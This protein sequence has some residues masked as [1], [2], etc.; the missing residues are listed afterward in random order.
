MAISLVASLWISLA[1]TGAAAA[2]PCHSDHGC[3]AA[4][5]PPCAYEIGR[6]V[7]PAAALAEAPANGAGGSDADSTTVEAQTG[8]P[9]DDLAATSDPPW[10]P[11]GPLRGER[12]WETALRFPGRLV[13]LPLS[14]MGDG[15]R[16][17]LLFIESHSVVPRVAVVLLALPKYNFRL[18]P[19]S[20]GERT[21]TGISGGYAPHVFRE[22]LLLE[23]SGSTIGYS[24]GRVR[25]GG[26][27]LGVEYRYD[28][29]PQDRFYGTGIDAREA[30]EAT[31]A[32]QAE[33]IRL[34]GAWSGTP[35]GSPAG[36]LMLEAWMGSRSEVTRSGRDHDLTPFETAFP[37]LAGPTLDLREEHLIYGAR[38]ALERRSG[39]PHWG[40]GYRVT[41]SG[42]RFDR[43]IPALALHSGR[44]SGAQ[45][46]RYVLEVETG[47]SFMRDPRTLRVS[48]RAV[49]QEISD[50]PTAFLVPDLATLGGEAGLQGFEPQ[51]FHGLDSAV[52][53]LSYI[54]PLQQHFEFD[55]HVEAGGVYTDL[56]HE[57]TLASLETSYGVALRPRTDA[58][59]LGFIGVD[60]CRET[61][62]FRFGIGGVE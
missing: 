62:R 25:L 56:Q 31:L 20:L 34:S 32:W 18:E 4:G 51:R 39:R 6:T 24:R 11:P 58:A 2:S 44:P 54:F 3:R 16:S 19:A 15:S 48:F 52:G 38:A 47:V 27:N 59:P 28:W 14:L 26:E 12:P 22:R 61:V 35:P 5:A 57:A 21:G 29:R 10:N 8:D 17:T 7:V 37:A 23:L 45:F 55:V 50:N 46:T 36:P 42:E 33:S 43:P 30:D 41:M 60:W 13:S 40:R 53:R 49:D 1:I 9:D